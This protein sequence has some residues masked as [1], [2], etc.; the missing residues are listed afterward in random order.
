MAAR[1]LSLG[2]ASMSEGRVGLER[3]QNTEIAKIVTYTAT[4]RESPI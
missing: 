2:S 3:H 4:R 1:S